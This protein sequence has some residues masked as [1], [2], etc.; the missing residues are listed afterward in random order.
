MAI[1]KKSSASSLLTA[2][3]VAGALALGAGNVQARSL[4]N[5]NNL[6]EASSVRAAHNLLPEA[7]CGAHKADSA[8]AG[9][10][11]KTA[12]GKCGEGKCG[13]GKKKDKAKAGAKGKTGE[14]SCGGSN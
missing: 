8:K 2:T 11:G 10:K 9:A 13:G 12:E 4:Y 6:G 14:H 7:G 1:L 3:M 5:F